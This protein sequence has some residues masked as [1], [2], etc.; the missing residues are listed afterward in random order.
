MGYT[1]LEALQAM[2]DC[3]DHIIYNEKFANK[4]GKAFGFKPN[5][6]MI[7]D[8]RSQ[9]KGAY[10]PEAKEG[11]SIRG[12]EDIRLCYQIA[13]HIGYDIRSD[14]FGSGSQFRGCIQELI[15]QVK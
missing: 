9:F 13:S 5:I 8:T 11:D 10:F 4:I 14:F 15:E 3:G 2:K 12:V 1:K 7:V 6:Q